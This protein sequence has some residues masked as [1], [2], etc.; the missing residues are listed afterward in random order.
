MD[1][2]ERAEAIIEVENILYD[3]NCTDILKGLL[4]TFRADP[5]QEYEG[6]TDEIL[7][8]MWLTW[9][10]AEDAGFPTEA[11]KRIIETWA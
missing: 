7:F 2:Q 8:I 6:T 10:Y 4:R 11:D 1:E 3:E 9:R 5:P